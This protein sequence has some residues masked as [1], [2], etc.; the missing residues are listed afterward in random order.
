MTTDT[1]RAR[2]PR[3][4]VVQRPGRPKMV[5]YVFGRYV[6]IAHWVRNGA[7]IWLVLSGIYIGNPFLARNLVTETSQNF[8]LAQVRG[9]H[10]AAGWLLLAMTLGRIYQFLFVRADG[11]LG[12]GQELRMAPILFNWKAWRDQLAFYVLARRDHPHFAYSNYGPLQ[13]LTYTVLYASLLLISVTGILLA[14]P[15]VH[16]GLA[17]VGA[18][19]LRPIEVWMGG[20]ANVRAVHRFTMMW[21]LAFFLLHLYM[22]VW[23]SLRT[24]NMMLE[25]MVSGFQA[26]DAT[27][28]P[29]DAEDLA[30]TKEDEAS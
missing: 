20:L 4:V 26:E 7:L 11:T 21:F 2:R 28:R 3:A 8:L 14:A 12:L 15:Y 17:D 18:G 1:P 10:V 5:V 29:A 16:G 19:L 25:S 24:G 30:G 22:V 27:A 23:N 9:W 6:R 13:Y